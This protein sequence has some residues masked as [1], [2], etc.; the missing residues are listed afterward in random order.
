MVEGGVGSVSVE[1]GAWRVSENRNS[2][3]ALMFNIY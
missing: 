2:Q 3:W 1:V